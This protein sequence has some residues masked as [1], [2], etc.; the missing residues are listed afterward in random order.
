LGEVSRTGRG[1]F[2]KRTTT[3]PKGGGEYWEGTIG[4]ELL[5]GSGE[6]CFTIG[7]EGVFV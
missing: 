3:V 7:G 2:K 6:K 1:G 5:R 4:E